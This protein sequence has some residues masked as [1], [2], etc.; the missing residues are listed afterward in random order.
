MMITINIPS[1]L[2]RF[3]DNQTAVQLPID[4]T[5]NLLEVLCQQYEKLRAN[6][7]DEHGDLIPY[8]N[9]YINGQHLNQTPNRPIH[10]NDTIDVVT[11][12]VGG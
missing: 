2:A 12:L 3:T 8:V 9:I 7:L 10:S 6:I 1:S 4:N 5:S 11:A